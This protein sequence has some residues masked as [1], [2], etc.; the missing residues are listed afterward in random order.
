MFC[1]AADTNTSGSVCVGGGTAGDPTAAGL[2]YSKPNLFNS[3]MH[4][5]HMIPEA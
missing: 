3:S 1:T 2:A 5:L 4:S